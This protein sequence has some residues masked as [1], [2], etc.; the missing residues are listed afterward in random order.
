MGH[1]HGHHHHGTKNLRVAFFLNLSFTIVEIVGGVLTN[2]LAILSDALHDLGD[3]LSI[4]LSWYFQKLSAKEGDRTFSYGYRRFSLLGAIVNSIVLLTGS[5][6]ILLEAIPALLDPGE[7]NAKG[8]LVLAVFGV[9]VNGAAVLNLKRG[10]SLNE[11]V[12]TLHLLEDVLGWGAVLIGSLAMMFWEI[13]IIDPLLSVLIAVFIIYNAVKNL[14][15]GFGI[16]LQAIPQGV[17]IEAIRRK[18]QNITEV[19]GIHDCH[20]WSMDGEYHVLSVHLVLGQAYHLLEVADIKRRAKALLKDQSIH[21]VTI[22]FEL[23]E[24]NCQTGR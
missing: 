12:I 20:V 6:F 8:M 9:L 4:G 11:K 22:E 5:V 14:R 3:S 24:E 21:H 1:H 15:K 16:I 13:P 10:V 23:P 17:D 18:L 19:G 7:A 2:S